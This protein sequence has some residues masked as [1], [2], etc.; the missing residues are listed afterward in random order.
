MLTYRTPSAPSHQALQ[1]QI[2]WLNVDQTLIEQ[3]GCMYV[4]KCMHG[5][6]TIAMQGTQP[7]ECI[8]L[9]GS[10]L[11][12][13]P[14]AFPSRFAVKNQTQYKINNCFWAARVLHTATSPSLR[15]LR[16]KH[17]SCNCMLRT[18]AAM[19]CI[20]LS[21][22]LPSMV[23]LLLAARVSHDPISVPTTV[24]R[25]LSSSEVCRPEN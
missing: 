17:M 4:S 22:T 10:A 16:G 1:K 13:F 15:L 20:Q 12:C 23:C 6:A 21:M 8:A 14:S 3:Q 11:T 25:H 2:N 24:V 19:S 18:L 9:L 5:C 7:N